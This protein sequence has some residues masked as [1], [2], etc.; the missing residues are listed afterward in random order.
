MKIYSDAT[1]ACC[2]TR[3]LYAAGNSINK[4]QNARMASRIDRTAVAQQK[5]HIAN[6]SDYEHH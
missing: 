4:E 6:R 1:L 2:T 3:R 5:S